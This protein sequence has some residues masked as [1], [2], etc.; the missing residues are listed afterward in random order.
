MTAVSDLK[1]WMDGKLVAGSDAKVHVLAHVLHYGS[2]LFEGIRAYETHDGRTAIFRGKDHNRRLFDSAHIYRMHERGRVPAKM[3]ALAAEK[4]WKLEIPFTS[5]ETFEAMK[6]TIRA[7]NLKSCYIRPVIYRGMGGFGVNPL[8]NDINVFIAVWE[9]GAYLGADALEQ[10]VD[11]CVSSWTRSRPNTLPAGAKSAA[12]YMG[13]QLQK[14]EAII[15]GFTEGIGLDANG[16]VS[17]GSGENIFLIRGKH[18]YTTPLGGSILGGI[19]R[20]TIMTLLGD[21]GFTV[22]E[23]SWPREMLYTAD[24]LF[25]VGTAAEVTPIRSVDN[26]QVGAGARG[27][28]TTEVQK[29]YLDLVHGKLE[30]KWGFLDYV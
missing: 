2:A 22:K 25:F 10:G 6:E 8:K 16:L 12:N 3:A 7:N 29:R 28:I 18:I 9:W 24:E 19:T 1:V 15:N 21:M 23:Q 4:G 14:M 5:S 20:D 26:R 11:V 13:G 30:D 17:E 27:P